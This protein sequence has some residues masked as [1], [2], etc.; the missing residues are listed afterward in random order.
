MY[1]YPQ[2]SIHLKD[3]ALNPISLLETSSFFVLLEDGLSVS[4][5]I[6]GFGGLDSSV[7]FLKDSG[8]FF[9]NL[10]LDNVLGQVQTFFLQE[11]YFIILKYPKL[12]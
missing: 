6:S 8:F 10:L 12:P 1:L 2:S 5:R 11:C 9:K 4:K 3:N 7:M